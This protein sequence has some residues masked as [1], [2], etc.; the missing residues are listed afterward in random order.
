MGRDQCQQLDVV[1]AFYQ[2]EPRDSTQGTQPLVQRPNRLREVLYNVALEFIVVFLAASYSVI[3]YY[4]IAFGAH[5][6]STFY[7][8]GA[9]VIAAL[10]VLV[11]ISFRHYTKIQSHRKRWYVTAG[12]G[13]V[14]VAFSLFLSLLFLSKVADQYS[15]G[16]FLFQFVVVSMVIVGVRAITHNNCNRQE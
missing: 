7:V 16:A 14:G 9:L 5:L 11:S 2:A 8:W 13:A 6:S 15:R 1:S 3:L 12:I 10:I 4:W